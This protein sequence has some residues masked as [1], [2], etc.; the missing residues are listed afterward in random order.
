MDGV[1]QIQGKWDMER[2][3]IIPPHPAKTINISLKSIHL[4]LNGPAQQ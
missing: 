1:I 3:I 2:E 4:L